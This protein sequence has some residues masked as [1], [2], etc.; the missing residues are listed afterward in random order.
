MKITIFS[1]DIKKRNACS[2]IHTPM[3]R[4]TFKEVHGQIGHKRENKKRN[5]LTIPKYPKARS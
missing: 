3:Q 5:T 4:G 1:K 2:Y